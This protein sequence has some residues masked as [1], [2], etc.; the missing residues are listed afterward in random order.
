MRMTNILVE[1][2]FIT[3]INRFFNVILSKYDFLIKKV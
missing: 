3:V 1:S 2:L